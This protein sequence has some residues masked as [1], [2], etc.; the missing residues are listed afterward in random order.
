MTGSPP[1]LCL[2]L[3]GARL[4]PRAAALTPAWLWVRQGV[5][6]HLAAHPPANLPPETVH[7]HGGWAVEPLADAHVHLFLCGAF[8][9]D[10]RAATAAQGRDAALQRIL[11]LLAAYRARGIAAVRDGGDPHGLALEAAAV[12]N[13]HPD[14]YAA[15]LPSGEPIFRRGCYGGFLGAGVES[16]PDA[17]RLMERNRRRGATQAKLLATG[18]NSLE[19]PGQVGSPQFDP[20]ELRVIGAAA[21]ALDLPTMVHANGPLG[22]ILSAAPTS[23]EHGFWAEPLDLE[24]LA[25]RGVAWVPTLGAWARLAAHPN[26]TPAQQ[27]VVAATDRRHR[28]EVA[29]G[30]CLGVRLTAGSDAGTPGVRHGAGL[31]EEIERLAAAG[32]GRQAALAAATYHARRLCRDG[33]GGALERLVNGGPGG[34]LWLATDPI[35]DPEALSTPRGVFLGGAWSTRENTLG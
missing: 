15:V 24:L 23:V 31:L 35:A 21:R 1:S 10:E 26:L 28:A 30:F 34:F 17:V 16:L 22:T 25:E 14:R 29:K 19:Q 4:G 13:R 9:K 6:E 12:A 32:L 5:V 20:Q 11:D 8:S 33:A 7:L 2:A 27:Q 3:D 18:L